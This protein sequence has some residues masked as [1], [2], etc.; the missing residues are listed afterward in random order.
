[1]LNMY[2]I[3]EHAIDWLMTQLVS[4][5]QPFLAY[6][7]L[8][9]PH[10]PYLPRREFVDRFRDSWKPAPKPIK[11]FPEG[12]SNDHLNKERQVYDEYIAYADAEFG[13]LLDFMERNEVLDSSYVV[14]TSDHGEMFER[15]ILYHNSPTM[16]EPLI[17]VPLLISKPGTQKREDIYSSTSCV[18]ILPTLLHAVGSTIPDWCEGKVLPTFSN[19]EGD[20]RRPIFLVDGRSNSKHAP[21]AKGTVAMIE[22]R[23]KLINYFGYKDYQNEY[24]LYDIHNDPEELNDLNKS[25]NSIGDD[26][27]ELLS[28][29]IKEVNKTY[30]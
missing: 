3:L 29:K 11:F 12:H 15:G 25:N 13:R 10:D 24:E 26:L 2:F 20:S 21:L 1:M 19:Q 6:V 8:L 23:Y 28:D 27:K 16:Y 30:Q 22:D 5:P 17:R 4:L 9:P 18:D 14:F 7:H